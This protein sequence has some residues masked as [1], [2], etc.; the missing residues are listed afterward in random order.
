MPISLNPIV[1][2]S[3]I[4]DVLNSST[5]LGRLYHRLRRLIHLKPPSPSVQGAA[6]AGPISQPSGPALLESLTG[7]S[8]IISSYDLVIAQQGPTTITLPPALPAEQSFVIV[9]GD[10]H[11][12]YPRVRNDEPFADTPANRALIEHWEESFRREQQASGSLRVNIERPDGVR[13][14]VEDTG[15]NAEGAGT[16]DGAQ[17]A[18]SDRVRIDLPNFSEGGIIGHVHQGRQRTGQAPEGTMV[19]GEQMAQSMGTVESEDRIIS[20][21]NDLG[22][23][24]GLY[25]AQPNPNGRSYTFNAQQM[26]LYAETL[27]QMQMGAI[28]LE[29]RPNG[30]ISIGYKASLPP[31]PAKSKFDIMEGQ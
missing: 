15:V 24:I 21:R 12:T 10:G 2:C 30:T 5:L 23:Q 26:A 14:P 29:Q 3:H 31:G 8:S 20:T 1:W 25:G 9:R 19:S 27:S 7:G 11:I 18:P 16:I 17:V 13:V 6:S 28:E 22:E 4:L